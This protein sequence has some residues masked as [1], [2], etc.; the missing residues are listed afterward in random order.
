MFMR[1][2]VMMHTVCLQRQDTFDGSMS[3]S[4]VLILSTYECLLVFLVVHQVSLLRLIKYILS[5][6]ILSS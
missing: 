6:L 5:Y 2:A 1:A 3:I 4:I